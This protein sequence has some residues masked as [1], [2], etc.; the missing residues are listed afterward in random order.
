MTAS[1]L[2]PV[3]TLRRMFVFSVTIVIYLRFIILL[4]VWLVRVTNK[5]TSASADWIYYIS[6]TLALLIT[7]NCKQY[8]VIVHLHQ[9]PTTVANA[10]GFPL[11]PLVVP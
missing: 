11:F 4:R 3:F 2:T 1:R 10:L 7:I 8:T 6:V 5:R 9:I